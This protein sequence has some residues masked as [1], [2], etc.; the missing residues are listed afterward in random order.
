MELW[1]I[2]G[3]KSLFGSVT[4]PGAKNVLLPMLAA[5]LLTGG[6][7]ELTNCPDLPVIDDMLDVLRAL[8]CTAQRQEDVLSIDTRGLTEWE[9]PVRE[10]IPAPAL[11]IGA[12]L[13]RCGR[14]KLSLPGAC[15]LRKGSMD[16]PLYALRALGAQITRDGDKLICTAENGLVGGAVSLPVPDMTATAC[17]MTAACAARGAT[18]LINASRQPEIQELQG[19]LRA[20]G[21]DMDGAG[22]NII[23]VRGFSPSGKTGWRVMPDRVNAAT[24]LCACACAGGEVELR[25]V[26]PAHFAPV[27]A[28]LESMGCESAAKSRS[29]RL[30]SRGA[31]TGGGTVIAGEYPDLPARA[32][33]L[34]MAAAAGAAGRTVFVESA[35]ASGFPQAAELARMGAD[36]RV[37]GRVAVVTGR[38]GKLTGCSVLT[39]NPWS[40]ASLVLAGLSAE[41]ETTIA[42]HGHISREYDGLDRQLRALGAEIDKTET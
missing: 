8:G 40:G 36:I 5:T 21:A 31:L 16:I 37:S 35:A 34:L 4:V 11:L 15:P 22:R 28:K 14:A 19:F 32:Q 6:E 27:T 9:L 7:T 18:T 24:L 20:L 30:K 38:E 1:K 13:G 33:P 2:E 25:G 39:E 17:A 42:D 26:T 10:N 41:G 29:L 12:L 3:G 23:T